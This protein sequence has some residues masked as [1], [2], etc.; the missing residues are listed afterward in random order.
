[1]ISFLAPGAYFAAQTKTH[2]DM[3]TINDD[4]AAIRALEDR[5]AAAVNAG[6][7][8]GI[9]QNYIPD[10]SLIVFDLVPRNEYRG[11][12]AYRKDWVDFYTHYKGLPKFLIVDLN[13]TV[14]GS[15]A[16]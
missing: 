16:F 15:L 4:E 6:D 13:V 1:M 8:N 3:K 14:E 10:K 9:M 2:Q 7:V 12:D 11:A 5:F